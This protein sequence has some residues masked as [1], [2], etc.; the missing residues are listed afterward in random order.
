[1]SW[2]KLEVILTMLSYAFLVGLLVL[3]R[4]RTNKKS[5]KGSVDNDLAEITVVI[6]FRNEAENLKRLILDIQ[7]LKEFPTTFVFVNDHS[8][9]EFLPLFEN[10]SFPFQLLYLDELAI[11]KK[12]GIAAGVA[13]AKTKY[14]LTWDA[15]IE[16]AEDYFSELKN[17]QWADLTILPVEMRGSKFVAGFFAMDYQLQSQAN[18]ALTGF[19]RPITA[20]GANLLFVKEVY[21]KLSELRNDSA[22]ASGDDQFLLKAM[23][24]NGQTIGVLTDDHLRVSTFAPEFIQAGMA[25]RT[26]W[27]N[28]TSKVGDGLATFFG[29]FVFLVQMSYYAFAFY[30]SLLGDWGATIVMVLIKGELDAFLTTYKFQE[31]FNTVQVFVYQ[32]I[33][34]FY[35]LALSLMTFMKKPKW[36][37]RLANN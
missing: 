19:F 12:A 11:G 17:W 18:V 27:L 6:P 7:K 30:Q 24:E 26:R 33:Y 29:G 14:V 15:D 20:S 16:V 8:E 32:L 35:I 37:G 21:L 5:K 1:M 34:P 13:F 23:R 3:G 22:I 10:L 31:Q 9:D 4:K 28:K 25:Q 36:K 2:F